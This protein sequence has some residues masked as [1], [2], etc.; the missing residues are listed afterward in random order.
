[1]SHPPETCVVLG[2]YFWYH[3][4]GK[5]T[6]LLRRSQGLD[7]FPALHRALLHSH[8]IEIKQLHYLWIFV[9]SLWMC[10]Y[11]GLWCKMHCFFGVTVNT[12]SKAVKWSIE[13]YVWPLQPQI[14]SLRVKQLGTI[15]GDIQW[16]YSLLIQN[17]ANVLQLLFRSGKQPRS[18]HSCLG[19]GSLMPNKR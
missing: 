3:K 15:E 6:H 11:S 4:V 14:L 2:R 12:V 16:A 19:G 7:K 10:V 13:L 9:E 17:V 1:M 8:S 18:R 5:G